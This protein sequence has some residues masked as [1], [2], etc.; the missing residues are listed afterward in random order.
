MLFVRGEDKGKAGV[1]FPSD[2]GETKNKRR[3]GS[4]ASKERGEYSLGSNLL[5]ERGGPFFMG[6]EKAR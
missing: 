4:L 2:H 3:R 1:R 6:A 5:S